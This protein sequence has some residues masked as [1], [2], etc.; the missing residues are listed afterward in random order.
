LTKEQLQM[1][2]MLGITLSSITDDN[3]QLVPLESENEKSFEEIPQHYPEDDPITSSDEEEIEEKNQVKMR[4]S[5]EYNNELVK[6]NEKQLVPSIEIPEHVEVKSTENQGPKRPFLRRG[7]GLTSR[8]GVSPDQFNLKN[9]PPYKYTER[10]KKT[11]GRSSTTSK[12]TKTDLTSQ[13]IL[14]PEIMDSKIDEQI[15]PISE[16]VTQS[17]Q[18]P[19]T[20]EPTKIEERTKPIEKII[21]IEQQITETPKNNMKVPKGISWAQILSENN[22]LTCPAAVVGDQFGGDLDD[23]N[24]FQMLENKISE[25]CPETSITSLMKMLGVMKFHKIFIQ[26][27][28]NIQ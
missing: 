6:N 28:M 13:K 18:K 27:L 21:P 1:Y 11:L 3:S 19:D 14:K 16:K 10:V 26:I 5:N 15:K 12:P 22:I 7:S 8:F 17:K 23:T 20:S 24:L 4:K 2:E 25:T 9:L